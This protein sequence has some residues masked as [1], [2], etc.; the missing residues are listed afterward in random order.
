MASSRQR[1]L[2]V[3]S[4]LVAAFS[5]RCILSLSVPALLSASILLGR[6]FGALAGP[7]AKESTGS[8]AVHND[9]SKSATAA[10]GIVLESPAGYS[11]GKLWL[12]PKDWNPIGDLPDHFGGEVTNY[13]SIKEVGGRLSIPHDAVIRYR[14]SR[15]I[16][17]KPELVKGLPV[18]MVQYLDLCGME[19]N[20]QNISILEYF[21]SVR[22]LELA[23]ADFSDSQFARMRFYPSIESVNINQTNLDGAALKNLSKLPKL[24]NFELAKAYIQPVAF[25][26]IPYMTGLK[27]LDLS[28]T[29]VTDEELEKILRGIPRLEM[30]GLKACN[31]LTA[32]CAKTIAAAP[33]LSMVDV[34]DTH[35]TAKM[36]ADAQVGERKIKWVFSGVSEH[37][38]TV[39]EA[40]KIFHPLKRY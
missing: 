2:A 26:Q 14:P 9:K 32:D 13:K 18:Q 10:G 3:P 39:R 20:D 28:K 29:R 24:R 8:P 23:S 31:K 4:S 11:F 27:R 16:M 21:S 37:S 12:C 19:F 34:V 5:N 17:A 36:M 40:E 15:E 30:L 25:A 22:K 33:N 1:L 7:A 35:I 6:S 38:F